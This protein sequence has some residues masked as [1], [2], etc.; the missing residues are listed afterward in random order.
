MLRRAPPVRVGARSSVYCTASVL[1][2]FFVDSL[3]DAVWKVVPSKEANTSY[4]IAVIYAHGEM[5]SALFS[6][7]NGHPYADRREFSPCINYSNY[8]RAQ[9]QI[10]Y[11]TCGWIAGYI[12]DRIA[13][14]DEVQ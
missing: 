5:T 7:T 9:Q 2:R 3:S 6:I 10:T 8:A 13:I 1:G 4:R 12:G 14:Q 11:A